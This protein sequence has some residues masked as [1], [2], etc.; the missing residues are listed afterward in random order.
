MILTRPGCSLPF[1]EEALRKSLPERFTQVVSAFPDRIA[2]TST[3]QKLTFRQLDRLAGNLSQGLRLRLGNSPEPVGL[4]FKNDV[5]IIIGIFGV[6]NSGKYY[7]ALNPSDP[8]YRMKSILEDLKSRMLIT[9]KAH[10]ELALE[11]A[12][13]DCTIIMIDELITEPVKELPPPELASTSLAGIFYT[14]GSTGAPK[15]VP[16]DHGTILHRSWVDASDFGMNCED[17]LIL[18]RLC[19]FSGSLVDIFSS[20]LNGASVYM[21]DMDELDLNLLSKVIQQEKITFFH[22]PIEFFRNI[23]DFLPA[24]SYFPHIRYIILSGDVLYKKDVERIRPFFPKEMSIVHHLSSSETGILAR[25]LISNDTQINGDIIPVGY[26]ISGKELLILGEGGQLLATGQVGEIAVRSQFG[27]KQYW[28]MPEQTEK[29]FVDD[30]DK[31]GYQIYL[32]GD[33]G[34]INPT[35]QLEF[36]GRKDL[37]VKIRGFRVD[38]SAIENALMQLEEIQ[39]AVVVARPDS[40]GLKRL[41]AYVSFLEGVKISPADL[42]FKLAETLPDYMIPGIFVTLR[43]FPLTATGKVDRQSLP[44]PVERS[45]PMDSI[46]RDELERRLADIWKQVL[47]LK[48]VGIEDE[49]STLGGHSLSA[50]RV[51]AQIQKDISPKTS[52]ETLLQASTIAQQAEVIRNPQ[53]FP[54][55]P[56]LVPIQIEGSLPPFFCVSPTVIDVISYRDL[57]RALGPDQPFYALYGPKGKPKPGADPQD[58]ISIFLEAVRRIQPSGPY[59]LGGYS[60]GG[61]LALRMAH[62]LE[63][64]GEKSGLVVLLDSLAPSYPVLLPWITPRMYN[65]LRVFRR[66]QTYLWKFWI[67]DFQEKRNLLLSGERPFRSRFRDWFSKRRQE[68]N[69]PNKGLKLQ[70]QG[71]NKDIEYLGYSGRVVLLRARQGLLG[72]QKNTTLGWDDYLPAPPEVKVIAGDHESILFG[73]RVQTVAAILEDCLKQAYP[74]SSTPGSGSTEC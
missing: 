20:L 19:S 51:I 15:G 40:N 7:C 18:L 69:K 66:V 60:G 35:G 71:I 64:Q 36:V 65:Y 31:P 16:R 14:S 13:D 54:D 47:G 52:F 50:L 74:Q 38:L 48:N 25:F 12:P 73:P 37:Q 4:L 61:K 6:I 39:R 49:F 55:L 56:Y 59:Y 72:V 10:Q 42:Q 9:D 62:R 67:L 44:E 23:I 22:P 1:K 68:I 28:N 30:P 26:P 21:Q 41:I 33:L 17:R 2:V 46:P 24:G 8:A 58:Q 57:S 3:V 70:S 34:R 45:E 11:V 27:F 29:K 53:Y 43:R 5:N 32:T 63:T